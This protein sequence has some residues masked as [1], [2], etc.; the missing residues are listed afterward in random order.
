[1]A[2]HAPDA[3]L[4]T[5]ECSEGLTRAVYRKGP[6][7]IGFKWRQSVGTL[8]FANENQPEDFWPVTAIAYAYAWTA[9][10]LSHID[11]EIDVAGPRMLE[12][13]RLFSNEEITRTAGCLHKASHR[14]GD[15]FM[16]P[17]PR[18]E[19][20]FKTIRRGWRDLMDEIGIWFRRGVNASDPQQRLRAKLKAKRKAAAAVPPA[21]PRL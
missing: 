20:L 18:P 11:H 3:T 13:E 21:E 16:K 4:V 17:A 15:Q 7:L 9:Q 8:G 14:Y 10:I 1:M 2:A 19:T 6:V 5:S 12:L